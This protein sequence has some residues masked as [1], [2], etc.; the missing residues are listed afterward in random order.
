MVDQGPLGDPV[1]TFEETDFPPR[2]ERPTQG[3]DDEST[4]FM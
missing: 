1:T 3:G 4:D 2:P